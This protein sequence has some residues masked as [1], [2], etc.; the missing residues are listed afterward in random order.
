MP[1]YQINYD[2]Q[3]YPWEKDANKTTFWILATFNYNLIVVVVILG[4]SWGRILRS[5]Y[6]FI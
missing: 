2:I 1:C 3:N 5:I 6:D 4:Q